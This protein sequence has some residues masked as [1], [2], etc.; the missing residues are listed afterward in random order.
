MILQVILA[1]IGLGC[2]VSMGVFMFLSWRGRSPILFSLAFNQ[3]K[4][5]PGQLAFL[6]LA[7]TGLFVCIF[8]GVEAML[9]WLP[10]TWGR[11][12]EDGTFT[13][14]RVT[15]ASLYAGVA[16]GWVGLISKVSYY[17]DKLEIMTK[18]IQGLEKIL[19]RGDSQYTL[20]S[21][22]DEFKGKRTELDDKRARSG[23]KEGR[24]R[25]WSP[26]HDLLHPDDAE[27]MM[28][29]RLVAAVDFQKKKLSE[30]GV[31]KQGI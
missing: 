25:Q 23:R 7:G 14:F 28:Y 30:S 9:F 1:L 24:S 15:I 22:M 31:E 13:A 17:S 19:I 6:F 20:D 10:D 2:V 16:L 26:P 18:E 3:T 29:G 27:M 4:F 5:S 12:D 8:Q 21:L 11:F